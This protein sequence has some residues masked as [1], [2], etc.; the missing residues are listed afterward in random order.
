MVV[1]GYF[2]P[3]GSFLMFPR[4]T[5]WVIIAD[6]QNGSSSQNEQDAEQEI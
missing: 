1:H 6:Q 5:K 4:P 3:G 2:N